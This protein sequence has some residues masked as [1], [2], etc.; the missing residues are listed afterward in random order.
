MNSSL[1]LP[2]PTPRAIFKLSDTESSCQSSQVFAVMPGSFIELTLTPGVKPFDRG[3]FVL[4][5]DFSV[6]RSSEQVSM[7]SKQ[8]II[9]DY[10]PCLGT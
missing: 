10:L 1:I 9:K 3:S 2:N 5:L 4:A 7:S 6:H 8:L